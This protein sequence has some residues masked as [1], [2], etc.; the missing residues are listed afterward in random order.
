MFNRMRFV[1]ETTTQRKQEALLE[2]SFKQS[3]RAKL[4][5]VRNRLETMATNAMDETV[6]VDLNTRL[7]KVLSSITP[8]FVRPIIGKD[9]KVSFEFRSF[10]IHPQ[11][12]PLTIV[13]P[14]FVPAHSWQSFLHNRTANRLRDALYRR[15]N[16]VVVSVTQQLA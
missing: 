12:V 8:F 5:S 16:T 1:E 2:R 11:D 3:T 14:E 9:G 15:P 7:M 4:S 10:A 13:L 6:D